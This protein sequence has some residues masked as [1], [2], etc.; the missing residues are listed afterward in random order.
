MCATSSL[1]YINHPRLNIKHSTPSQEQGHLNPLEWSLLWLSS[2]MGLGRRSW[3]DGEDPAAQCLRPQDFKHYTQRAKCGWELGHEHSG[4][5]NSGF[6]C[7]IL[8][9]LLQPRLWSY[10][11]V[12]GSSRRGECSIWVSKAEASTQAEGRAWLPERFASPLKGAQRD[13]EP[14]GFKSWQRS[15]PASFQYPLRRSTW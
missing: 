14:P 7:R 6:V 5:D 1:S 3:G 2:T 12:K 10:G 11:A 4:Q 9:S 13:S 8:F 15:V